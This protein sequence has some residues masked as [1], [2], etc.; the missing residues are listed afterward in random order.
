MVRFAAVLALAIGIVT[1]TEAEAGRHRRCNRARCRPACCQPVCCPSSTGCSADVEVRRQ[2]NA[3]RIE[4]N[5]D[6]LC[7]CDID[8][9]LNAVD[10]HAEVSCDCGIGS[11]KVRGTRV[12]G[13]C[14]KLETKI[15]GGWQYLGEYC[16]P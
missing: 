15:A 6:C 7:D 5:V 16:L 2:G 1:T 3:L 10:D 11:F 9:T 8:I 12:N 14:I 4:G 13:R